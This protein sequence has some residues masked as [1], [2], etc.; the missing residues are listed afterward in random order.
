MLSKPPTKQQ[1]NPTSNLEGFDMRIQLNVISIKASLIQ[2][3]M[4]SY[5]C[6]NH[7]NIINNKNFCPSF[8]LSVFSSF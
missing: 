8:H 6:K 4:K 5:K 1:P 7:N 3:K 2:P